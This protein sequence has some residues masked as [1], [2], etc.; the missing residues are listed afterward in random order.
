MALRYVERN[1]VRAN[2]V[3]RP[4]EYRW[5]R[6]AAHTGKES[7]GPLLD[8]EFHAS[9]GGAERWW[10]LLAEPE[11]LIA[12]RALLRGTF[13]GRPVGISEFAAG[14]ERELGRPLASRQGQHPG[15]S[16]GKAASG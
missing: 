6:A 2:L 3:A 13:T 15:G 11:E 14:L 12:I 7:A 16:K 9:A 1:A 10:G 4:E 5:S 8:W